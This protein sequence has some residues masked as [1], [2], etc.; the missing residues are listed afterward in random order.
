[1]GHRVQSLTAIFKSVLIMTRKYV[2]FFC[3]S[4]IFQKSSVVLLFLQWRSICVILVEGL[5]FNLPFTEAWFYWH[6]WF[7]TS[8]LDY[9][10]VRRDHFLSW[11]GYWFRHVNYCI[12]VASIFQVS[13]ISS[14][15]AANTK[16]LIQSDGNTSSLVDDC[17]TSA[18]LCDLHG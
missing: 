13:E 14:I 11:R 10:E 5:T 4:K 7:Y 2:M 15:V 18:I 8:L 17:V 1:M 16:S 3:C 12:L 9:S 6:D